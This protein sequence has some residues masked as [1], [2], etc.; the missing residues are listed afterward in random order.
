MGNLLSVSS[1]ELL[2]RLGI[3]T[4]SLLVLVGVLYRRRQSAPAMPLV[5]A[6][7]NLGLF[8]ALTSIS[9]GDF[10]AGIGFGLFGLLS[11]V[12]LRSA[13]FTLKD[14]AYTFIA[15]VLALVNGLDQRN[16]WLVTFLSVLVLV[17][18]WVTDD[19]RAQ[20][21][22]RVMRLTLDHLVLEP[23]AV[24]TEL[25][26]RLRVPILSAVIDDVDFVRETTRVSVRY[27]LPESAWQWTAAPAEV[28]EGVPS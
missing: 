7:L 2:A 10:K 27:T 6:A 14:V 15:L 18:V 25:S 11:L 22:T 8:A 12:R 24:L 4:L 28:T 21:A 5:F 23:E 9:S 17:A 1:A 13:A 20:P 3:D 26:A 19:S 16:L